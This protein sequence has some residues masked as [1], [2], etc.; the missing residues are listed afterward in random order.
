LFHGTPSTLLTSYKFPIATVINGTLTAVPNAIRAA[1]GRLL[2]SSIPAAAKARIASVLAGYSKRL[3]WTDM[4]KSDVPPQIP[5]LKEGQPLIAFVEGSPDNAEMVRGKPMVGVAGAMFD[6]NYL[7][8]LGLKRSDVAIMHQV[9]VML[10]GKDGNAR[11]PKPNEVLEWRDNLAQELDNLDPDLTIALGQGIGDSIMADFVL[12]HPKVLTKMAKS[13]SVNLAGAE[14]VRKIK[15]IKTVLDGG[16]EPQFVAI[17]MAKAAALPLA[18]E[19]VGW[20]EGQ[21]RKTLKA[22]AKK[23]DGTIDTGKYGR[24]FLYDPGTGKTS[25][26]KFPIATV[27]DGVLFAIPDAIH[28]AKSRFDQAQGIPAADKAKIAGQLAAYSKKL[29]WPTGT[30]DDTNSTSSNMSKSATLSDN[31]HQFGLFMADAPDKRNVV[32]GVVYA[33]NQL[34]D[35]NHWAP[36]E[37]LQDAAHW[38]ME[39]SQLADTEHQ[40]LADARVVESYITSQPEKLGDRDIPVGSWRVAHSV[41]DDLKKEIDAGTYKGQSMFG[42]LEGLYGEAPPGY[43]AKN[44]GDV[45]TILK[46]TKIRPATVGFVAVAANNMHTIVATCEGADCPLN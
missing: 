38:Y 4:H 23:P 45:D 36:P 18:H 7:A 1:K 31:E 24:A 10:M 44:A 26:M 2:G 28:A 30:S 17:D 42:R 11:G 34:D 3:G 35:Q 39:H 37:V 32:Q 9:P 6:K 29:G 27:I 46:L 19:D 12:P 41:S 22:W 40:K 8:P 25:D 21:A 5:I 16:I 15:A 20:N 43:M 33:P 14:L 13:G